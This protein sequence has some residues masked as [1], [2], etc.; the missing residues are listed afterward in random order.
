MEGHRT[1]GKLLVI[2]VGVL[3]LT[4]LAGYF[5]WGYILFVVALI[6]GSRIYYRKR[7][8]ITYPKLT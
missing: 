3:M 1:I 2:G 4:L 6:I 7:F 8:L 5:F